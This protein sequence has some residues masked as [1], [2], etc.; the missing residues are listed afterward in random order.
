MIRTSSAA[1]CGDEDKTEQGIGDLG[2]IASG[3]ARCKGERLCE[4]ALRNF[5]QKCRTIERNWAD[6][7]AKGTSIAKRHQ[8]WMR[9]MPPL[10]TCRFIISSTIPSS[11][12]TKS[13]SILMMTPVVSVE[14]MQDDSNQSVISVRDDV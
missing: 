6:N 2:E 9:E 4:F 5:P 10:P 1:I 8:A 14:K 11:W 13:T 3:R 12:L 7:F